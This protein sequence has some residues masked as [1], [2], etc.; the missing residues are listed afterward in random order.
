[1]EYLSILLFEGDEGVRIS[2]AIAKHSPYRLPIYVYMYAIYVCMPDCVDCLV[3]RRGDVHCEGLY[4][5]DR[6]S[7]D[8]G[9]YHDRDHYHDNDHCEVN[10]GRRKD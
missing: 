1:M 9:C 6:G 5:A 2:P 7:Y 4:L 8:H 3:L 10:Y